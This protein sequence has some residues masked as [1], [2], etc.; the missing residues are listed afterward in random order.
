MIITRLEVENVGLFQGTH[1]IAFSPSNSRRVSIVVA[2]NGFGKSTLFNALHIGVFGRLPRNSPVDD[3]ATLINGRSD[4]GLGARVRVVVE[5][6]AEANMTV[7]I[8]REW[9]ND[10]SGNLIRTTVEGGTSGKVAGPL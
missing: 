10:G 9:S 2:G 5:G 7:A 3:L 4:P 8:T 6:I 1:R